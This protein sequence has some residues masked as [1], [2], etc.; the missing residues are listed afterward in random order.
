MKTSTAE[1]IFC[2]LAENIPHPRTELSYASNFE[3]LIAVLLSARTTDKSVNKA[4][5]AL[6]KA[7]NT[8][9]KILQLG[10]SQVKKYIKTLGFY[11]TKAANVIKTC[12][13]LV[14]KFNAKI[15]HTREELESLPGV[16]HKTASVILNVAFGNPT[17]AVDTHVFRV[18][19]RTGLALGNTPI[20][21]EKKLLK[22]IPQKYALDAQHLLLLHGRY[23]CVARKP[24]CEICPISSW[25]KYFDKQ[26]LRIK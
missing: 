10:V 22:I 17:V 1:K 23:T 19:N 15:P 8:P 4:T 18:A 3:L 26:L 25:C 13:I 9:E 2:A 6:F 12:K 24:K 7:A 11:N 20:A 14:E 21:V 5:A 16:G